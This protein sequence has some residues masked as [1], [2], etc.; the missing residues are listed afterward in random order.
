V[1]DHLAYN[2]AV[3]D[4]VRSLRES[5]ASVADIDGGYVVNG[6]QQY[7]H[8]QDAPR[9]TDGRVVVPGIT[10]TTDIAALRYVIAN[11][12]MAGWNVVRTFPYRRWLGRSG[13]VWIL[14]RESARTDNP[15][16]G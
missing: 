12:P 4:A 11:A 3:W 13:K 2:A 16:S 5:G 1:R 6:W 10:T 8:P 7:A 14:E 9:D 15:R